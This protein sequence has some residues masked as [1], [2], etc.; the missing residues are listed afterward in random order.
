MNLLPLLSLTAAFQSP[1][2]L[3]SVDRYVAGELE[4]QRVPALSIAILRGDSVL[5][6]R[7]YGYANVEHRVPATDSTIYQSG[8]VGKQFT[9]AAVVMLSE[10]G[11]LSLDDPLVRYLPE[12][13]AVW[14]GITIR[15]LL[16]HTSGIPDY[17]DSTL[18]YRHS[19]SEDE[20]VRLAAGLPLAFRPGERWSYSNTGY[21][22]LGVV[23]R[24]VT[25]SFYGEFLEKRIFGP[26]GM[27]TA[28]VISESEIVPN[29]AAGYR[30]ENGELLNQKWV[31]PELNTT[32]DG[33]LYLSARDLASWAVALNHGRTPS[34][35]ALEASWKPVRLNSG[36]FYPYGLGWRVAEQRGFRQI[37]HTGSWQ[38]FKTSIQRYPDFDLTVIVLANLAEAL[39]EAMSYGIAGIVEP[40][41]AAPHLLTGA[42]KGAG[43]PEPIPD[44]LRGFQAG[45]A[46]TRITPG[47]K[48]FASDDMRSEIGRELVGRTEWRFLGCDAVGGRKLSRLGSSIEQIC[49]ARGTGKGG[50]VLATVL[51]AKEWQAADI[52]WYEF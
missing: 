13:R 9:A 34:R 47:L 49:Y 11:R 27:R 40:R 37:G 45:S 20:L 31:A 51:Y 7:G 46:A 25:G 3:D 33:S 21:V 32:A 24:R 4:R 22:L 23:I 16:T 2:A 19:Y 29:R 26:V 14:R 8:S 52:D 48:G 15:H 43:P 12:G 50:D 38:G 39:P 6:G 35:S 10:E 30:L 42:L 41:L 17:A 28:R 5:L 1:A 36:G 18:D 44:L